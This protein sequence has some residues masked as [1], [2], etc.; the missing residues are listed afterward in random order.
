[1]ARLYV[2]AS[3]WKLSGNTFVEVTAMITR[4]LRQTTEGYGAH[5]C[6]WVS[7]FISF[8]FGAQVQTGELLVPSEVNGHNSVRDN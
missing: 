7:D 1:M 4:I 6:V 8:S 3:V 2:N 5:H